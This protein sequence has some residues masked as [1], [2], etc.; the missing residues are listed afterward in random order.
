MEVFQE[1]CGWSS[2][3]NDTQARYFG[4][5]AIYLY[6]AKSTTS[7]VSDAEKAVVAHGS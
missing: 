7:E 1:Q 4:E 5:W 2:N 3:I 6:D